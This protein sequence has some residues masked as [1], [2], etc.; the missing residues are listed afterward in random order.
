[1]FT[2]IDKAL[3][4][5]VMAIAFMLSQFGIVLPEWLSEGN[6]AIAAGFISTILVY[7]I[8]NKPAA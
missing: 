1:M 5:L 6:A 3:V 8:P 7:V 4:S 2:S